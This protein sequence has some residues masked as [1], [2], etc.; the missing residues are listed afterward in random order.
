MST[1]PG[2]P[3]IYSKN[4]LAALKERVNILEKDL[5]G[6]RATWLRD[7]AEKTGNNDANQ[8]MEEG[9]M[10]IEEFNTLELMNDAKKFQQVKEEMSLEL[11]RL[12]VEFNTSNQ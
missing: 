6:L 1:P 10:N 3:I 5:L 9:T 11:K 2:S 4:K 7:I 8:F 12:K